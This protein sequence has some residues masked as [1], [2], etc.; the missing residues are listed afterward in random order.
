MKTKT[1]IGMVVGLPLF[2]IIATAFVIY[3]FAKFIIMRVLYYA[4]VIDAIMYLVN[5]TVEKLKK[6][7]LMKMMKS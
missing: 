4:G 1:K 5:I 3:T 7:Q 6:Y 2:L